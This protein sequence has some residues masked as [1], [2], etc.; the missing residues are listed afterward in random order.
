MNI[1]DVFFKSVE[2]DASDIFISSG[3]V[4]VLRRNGG[5]VRLEG[6][7]AIAADELNGFRNS[8]LDEAKKL[9]YAKSSGADATFIH[10]NRRFRVNFFE[11]V[12]G[13]ALAARPVKLGKDCTFERYNIPVELFNKLADLQ[14]GLV[15][16]TGST[17]CGK[18]TTMSALINAINHRRSCHI[19]TLEDPVEFIHEDA[20]SL[21]SQRETGSISGGFLGAL[22]DA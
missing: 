12:N 18:S 2:L 13:P 15:L 10:E 3:K 1:P 14:R 22:H 21:I 5:L 7:Q 16:F 20:R 9:D 19:L 8:L 4:P 11:T 6:V 17:G